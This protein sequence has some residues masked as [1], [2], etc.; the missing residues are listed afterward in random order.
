MEKKRISQ[1]IDTGIVRRISGDK[2]SYIF[3]VA[4][5]MDINKKQIRKT[6]TWKP[7]SEL[8]MKKADKKAKEEYLNFKNRC[9]GLTSFNENMKF[10]ELCEKYFEFYV[11]NNLKPITAYN[12]KQMFN[13]RLIPFW[14]NKKLKDINTTM[15]TSYFCNLTK[16][17]KSGESISLSPGTIR[18]L[19]N[20]MQ[21][22]FHFAIK[23]KIIKENPCNGV[24]LP[25]YNPAQENRK[26]YLTE[27]EFPLFLSLFKKNRSDFDRIILLLLHTGM[28]AGELLGLSWD[29]IDFEHKQIFVKHTLSS[30]GGKHLLTSPKTQSSNRIIAMNSTVYDLLLIQRNYQFE[31][32]R[33]HNSFA[34]PEM[35]F[36]SPRGNYKDRSYLNTSFKKFLTGSKFEFMT[37]HCLR[38]SNATLL[39]N[40]GVDLKIVSEHLGHSNISTTGNIYTA[41][42]ASSKQK[43][44]D[45][46]ELK[47]TN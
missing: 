21:S 9:L 30:V 3:T 34:H 16:E 22:V 13:Y 7:S 38:H 25:K 23:Q 36:T 46:I 31:I 1:T 11:P 12:Y 32:I 29:D 41:I 19:F 10:K 6:T 8:T 35:V 18:R 44:A 2:F 43:T 17:T 5:G 15:L 40:S 4:C 45:I 26:K 33:L 47:L 42:L 37:L 20:M 27:E 28:R 39:L 14:G 24:E